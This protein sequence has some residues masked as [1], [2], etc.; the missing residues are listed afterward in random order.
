MKQTSKNSLNLAVLVVSCDNYSD[1]WQ[2]FFT[3]FRRFWP[4]CPYNIYLLSN[5][6]KYEEEGVTPILIGED[7]SWSDNLIN[8]LT[9]IDEE[10]VL[11]LIDDLF[12][13]DQIRSEQLHEV[14]NWI[15]KE[16]PNYVRLNPLPKPDLPYNDHVGLVSPGTL[17]RTATVM[18]VWNKKVLSDLL[19]PGENAWKFEISGT[20]RS[21]EYGGFYSAWQVLMPVVN[22]VIKGKWQRSAIKRL[23]ALGITLQLESR[24]TMTIG[25]T[26]RFHFVVMRSKAL[27]LFPPG[28][29]RYIKNLLSRGQSN[30]SLKK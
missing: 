12:L 10:Y 17:Y 9:L 15:A 23:H 28:Y 18:T 27:R 11:M 30:Y 6:E 5:F 21:D 3:L 19:R 2:P 1:L 4:D 7:L 16:K 13:V 14:F 20:V 22:G 26:I 8:A 24:R 29:R 25:E